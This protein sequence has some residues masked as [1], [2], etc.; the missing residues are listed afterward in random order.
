[1]EEKGLS[2]KRVRLRHS[3]VKE[4]KP[5]KTKNTKKK[6]KKTASGGYAKPGPVIN[7]SSDWKGKKWGG[8]LHSKHK[9][10]KHKGIPK[11]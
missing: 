11:K 4:Q 6:E 2:L 5:K 1:M 10:N 7:V 3:E 9:T 8:E